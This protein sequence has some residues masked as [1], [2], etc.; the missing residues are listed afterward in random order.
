MTTSSESEPKLTAKDLPILA[1]VLFENGRLTIT[2]NDA[3]TTIRSLKQA[4]VDVAKPR[5]YPF[6]EEDHY[7]QAFLR[8]L[9]HMT[10]ARNW[11]VSQQ[12]R[13][14]YLPAIKAGK[15]IVYETYETCL[16]CDQRFTVTIL[17][18]NIDFQCENECNTGDITF[19]IHFPTGEVVYADS[20]DRFGEAKESGLLPNVDDV[21]NINKLSNMYEWTRRYAAANI[22]FVFVGNTCPSVLTKPNGDIQIGGRGEN[23]EDAPEAWNKEGYICTDLWWA[24]LLDKQYYDEIIA[25]LP[26]KRKKGFIEKE[27]KSFK[28]RPGTYRFTIPDPSLVEDMDGLPYY[29]RGEFLHD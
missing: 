29:F 27:Y 18:N 19:D 2:G 7:Q 11:R 12:S 5:D 26:A 23:T 16:V 1:R 21:S 3:H 10:I 9:T 6:Q 14:D 17:G 22:A 13:T 4:L 25:K 15:P 8:F 24:T 20:P 28:V